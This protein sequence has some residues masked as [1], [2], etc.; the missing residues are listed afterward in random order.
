MSGG[1]HRTGLLL[2]ADRAGAGL[3]A[4]LG[5]GC[6]GSHGPRTVAVTLSRHIVRDIAVTA[7]AGIG[8]I[9][10]IGAGGISD[11]LLVAVTAANDIP[12]FG[13]AAD[14][15]G[16]LLLTIFGAGAGLH[17]FPF[18]EAVTQRGNIVRDIAAATGAGIGGIAIVGA[19]GCGDGLLVVVPGG[20]HIVVL[21]AV[22]ADRTGIGGIAHFGAGRLGLHRFIPVA[23]SRDFILLVA[24]SAGRAGIPVIASLSTGGR[25]SFYLV[26]VTLGGNSAGFTF[27]TAHGTGADFLTGFGA[28]GCLSLRPFAPIVGAGGGGVGVTAVGTPE[29]DDFGVIVLNGLVI[30]VAGFQT[31][32]F[33]LVFQNLCIALCGIH[34]QL[35]IETGRSLIC[36]L[37]GEPEQFGF[38]RDGFCRGKGDGDSTLLLLHTD[39]GHQSAVDVGELGIAKLLGVIGEDQL[40]V[41]HRLIQLHVHGQAV[42]KGIGHNR[43]H[44][45]CL[46]NHILPG[47]RCTGFGSLLVEGGNLG[48][49]AK[50]AQFAGQHGA[51][52]NGIECSALALVGVSHVE[53][54]GLLVIDHRSKL[55]GNQI[56]Y[57]GELQPSLAQP[58]AVA[59]G[60][61]INATT[62]V[63]IGVDID[64]VKGEGVQ[65][66]SARLRQDVVI[67]CGKAI[68]IGVNIGLAFLQGNGYHGVAAQQFIHIIG[69]RR[70][71]L[72]ILLG[73]QEIHVDTGVGDG[74]KLRSA[75]GEGGSHIRPAA[76][77]GQVSPCL[78]FPGFGVHGVHGL[79]VMDIEGIVDHAAHIVAASRA[80]GGPIG[81]IAGGEVRPMAVAMFI[82]N[83]GRQVDG[84]NVHHGETATGLQIGRGLGGGGDGHLAGGQETN[85]TGFVHSRHCFIGTAPAYA[86]VG[87]IPG[88]NRSG[89]PELSADNG[90]L[91]CSF[92]G[93]G[94]S[95]CAGLDI[96]GADFRRGHTVQTIDRVSGATGIV[97]AVATGIVTELESGTGF[98]VQTNEI[99]GRTAGFATGAGH[100]QLVFIMVPGHGTKG[101]IVARAA[102]AVIVDGSQVYNLSLHNVTLGEL[103]Q[104]GA[105]AGEG[106]AGVTVTHHIECAFV[107][108]GHHGQL[109]SG[110]LIL[111]G[112]DDRQVNQFFCRT[113]GQVNGEDVVAIAQRIELAVGIVEGHVPNFGDALREVCQIGQLLPCIV[114]A[115]IEL[116]TSV[117]HIDIAVHIFCGGDIQLHRHQI[118]HALFVNV[119]GGRDIVQLVR[120]QG[121]EAGTIAPGRALGIAEEQ[122]AVVHGVIAIVDFVGSFVGG[123]VTNHQN[124][125]LANLAPDFAQVD[126]GHSFLTGF[127]VLRNSLCIDRTGA[128]LHLHNGSISV[129]P[130]SDRQVAVVQ[131]FADGQNFRC[132]RINGEG[133]REINAIAQRTIFHHGQHLLGSNLTIRLIEF[134][135][136]HGGDRNPVAFRH[137]QGRELQVGVV[138]EHILLPLAIVVSTVP[139]IIDAGV[140]QL[141]AVLVRNDGGQGRGTTDHGDIHPVNH[142]GVGVDGFLAGG[143][144]HLHGIRVT[145]I[146][147]HATAGI[148]H[149]NRIG[150]G[151]GDILLFPGVDIVHIGGIEHG[152]IGPVAIEAQHGDGMAGTHSA[153]STGQFLGKEEALNVCA[154]HKVLPEPLPLSIGQGHPDSNPGRAIGRNLCQTSIE[155]IQKQVGIIG[156]DHAVA[157]QIGQL[158]IGE[159]SPVAQVIVQ[160]HLNILSIHDTVTIEVI[161]R[162]IFCGL[163]RR[164]I[165]QPLHFCLHGHGSVVHIP[166][167]A[168][169]EDALREQ[170]GRQEILL[171]PV[172]QV[173]DGEAEGVFTG[174]VGVG[175]QLNLDL[176]VC[177]GFGGIGLHP[178]IRACTNGGAHIGKACALTENGVIL[179]CLT[180]HG[181]GGGHQEALN[182]N[183]AADSGFLAE[184]ILPDILGHNAGQT[185]KL[186]CSHGSTG[187]QRICRARGHAVHGIDVAAGGN[188]LRLHLQRARHAPCGEIAHADVLQTGSAHAGILRNVHLAGIVQHIALFIGDGRGHGTDSSTGTHADDDQGVGQG[189]LG[190]IHADGLFIVVAN[191]GGNC[192][193]LDGVLTLLIEAQRL[194]GVGTTVTDGNFALQRIAQSRKIFLIAIAVNENILLLTSQRGQRFIG[195][196]H[197]GGAGNR[198]RIEDVAVTD[199]EIVAHIAIVV[200]RSH[201]QTV[202]IRAGVSN[203]IGRDI[204]RQQVALGILTGV[205][206]PVAIVT[207]GNGENGVGGSQQIHNLSIAIGT[208]ETGCSRTQRQVDRVTVQQDGIFNSS[209]IVR[210]VRPLQN[211]EDLHH[212]NLGIGGIA[213]NIAGLQRPVISALAIGNIAVG[214]G[215]T[216]NVRAVGA[217][218]I[219]RVVVVDVLMTTSNGVHIVEAKGYLHIPVHCLGAESFNP[220]TGIELGHNGRQF[221]GI[222]QIQ[223]LEV[224]FLGHFLCF[225]IQLQGISKGISIKTLVLHIQTGIDNGNSLT[226]TGVT[227]GVG[228]GSAHHVTGGIHQGV[229]N[230]LLLYHLRQIAGFQHHI[231]NPIH[232]LDVLYLAIGDVDGNDVGRQSQ[233]PLD[234]QLTP[235]GGLDSGSDGLLFLPQSV[236]VGHGGGIG[237]DFF[238]GESRLDGGLLLQNDGGADNLPGVMG[239]FRG[240]GF[241]RQPGFVKLTGVTVCPGE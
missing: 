104:E 103:E 177:P 94:D 235:D 136:R 40:A 63:F 218:L 165:H 149:H 73:N 194:A 7:G 164:T 239:V 186:R 60:D 16:T 28:G 220:L 224:F 55:T 43:L 116:A 44:G 10:I 67:A 78:G 110:C 222:Q 141:V 190:Q 15:A 70:N 113:G 102:V 3:G 169:G 61:D 53:H 36:H 72:Q 65:P 163:Y 166:G 111:G 129:V 47:L 79:A 198:L 96:A 31:D 59:L 219:Q 122:V 214:G 86:L 170:V 108:D 105:G 167:S 52:V 76:A 188:N 2:A 20:V 183:T 216:G 150:V 30:V 223:A 117:C 19:G 83:Q 138:V 208:G 88:A 50:V 84:S 12:G 160:H 197:T 159:L 132:L 189:V 201:G 13:F 231:L 82:G 35:G 133:E 91:H 207:H 51:G 4:L 118:L 233:I 199:L 49:C 32:G 21:V 124:T 174:A 1:L 227:A 92:H 107:I 24:V 87:Q 173:V 9:A 17:H 151:H 172:G 204:V 237:R 101:G 176:A 27:A 158:G 37:Q 46:C 99:G 54:T 193:I 221:F 109:P 81:G 135:N 39:S 80:G 215:D 74:D 225:G 200:R 181:S 179:P 134:R 143:V 153:V 127:G 5:T 206:C 232:S 241:F 58:L 66:Q 139:L 175:F 192:A 123:I 71:A 57:T 202:G 209:H 226:C 154:V 184:F 85:Q 168:I 128:A 155:H 114:D 23:L 45:F 185:G 180:L 196:G 236:P 156:I 38:G 131:I 205:G 142:G 212:Q 25:N 229:G 8:G 230:R 162:H 75:V 140:N 130:D 64:I 191:H 171:L 137:I 95:F 240:D 210:A 77:D 68:A 182:Q 238:G 120:V 195:V 187:V 6:G 157:I 121:Q 69:G 178:D 144:R 106:G 234:I 98:G 100:E 203:G 148:L 56:V 62:V 42:R 89:Q 213:L 48:G 152:G 34:H 145:G 18:A 22:T 211:A 115:H 93:D 97:S 14:R 26:A 119:R 90:R 228:G 161:L 147:S 125:S 146:I 33:L 11:G 41:G 126:N 112:V 29:G 217:L